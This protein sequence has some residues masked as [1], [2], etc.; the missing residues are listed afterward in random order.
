MIICDTG[1]LV[2]AVSRRDRHHAR[3][4]ELLEQ[5][6]RFGLV[7]PSTVLVEVDYLLRARVGAEAARAFLRD[8]AAGRFVYE[9]VNAAMLARAVEVDERH[10]DVGL[11]VVD[12]SVIACAEYH[13]R[14]PILTLDHQHFRLAAG[15]V[16]LIL[17][18]S[19][20]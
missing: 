13:G 2:A 15:E 8:V 10:A 17:D 14:A 1:P 3:C 20:L 7:V 19:A 18:E 12:G 9:P 16:P 6:R 5:H 4:R 11:G